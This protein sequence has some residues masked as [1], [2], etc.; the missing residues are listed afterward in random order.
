[1]Y[2]GAMQAPESVDA[3]TVSARVA[4]CTRIATLALASATAACSGA[5]KRETSALWDAVDRYRDADNA[6]KPV[7]G[8]AVAAVACTAASV[9]DAK[10]VC[11]AA[12]DPTTRALKLKD[13]VALRVA[14]IEQNHLD[15]TSPE[16]QALSGKLDLAAKLLETGRQK[17]GECERRLTD[18]RVQYGG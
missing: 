9:C 3:M 12:I 7:R 13:D 17:M 4:M 14:D 2:A 16:A 8:Q 6:S 10:R 11:L 5:A 15:A 1:V 18:L